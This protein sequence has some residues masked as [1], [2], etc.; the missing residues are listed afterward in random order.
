MLTCWK[1]GEGKKGER[2]EGEKKRE[3]KNVRIA[4]ARARRRDNEKKKFFFRKK[5]TTCLLDAVPVDRRGPAQQVDELDDDAVPGVGVNG[6]GRVLAVD[7]DRVDLIAVGRRLAPRG[8][9]FEPPRDGLG[10]RVDLCV[11]VCFLFVFEE[12]RKKRGGE[13]EIS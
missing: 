10:A 5:K 9:E 13:K 7:K 6:G 8:S 11:V 3:K 2:K 1:S 4:F 12:R